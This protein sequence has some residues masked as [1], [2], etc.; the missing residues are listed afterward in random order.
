MLSAA[1]PQRKGARPGK[2]FEALVWGAC[3][4]QVIRI[5]AS[6]DARLLWRGQIC[7]EDLPKPDQGK[8]NLVFGSDTALNINIP[9]PQRIRLNKVPPRLD[10]VA[11]QHGEHAVG[12]DGVV[13]LHFEQAAHGGVHGGFPQL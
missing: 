6:N 2:V 13:D 4:R 11:H 8:R 10:F 5:S 12:F 9:C 7:P 3:A 1:C